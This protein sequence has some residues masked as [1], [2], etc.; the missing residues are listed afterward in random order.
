MFPPGG[1]PPPPGGL[2]PPGEPGAPGWFP[3]LLEPAL[4]SWNWL[5]SSSKTR[6]VVAHVVGAAVLLVYC[7]E[8]VTA[9]RP[10]GAYDATYAGST[11]QLTVRHGFWLF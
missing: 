2:E 1:F 9:A 5:M 6:V 4:S 7:H 3:P 10:Y 11:R 8:P